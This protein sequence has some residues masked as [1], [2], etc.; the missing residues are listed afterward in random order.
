MVTLYEKYIYL[1]FVNW[2]D[3]FMIMKIN[4]TENQ[5]DTLPLDDINSTNSFVAMFTS[6]V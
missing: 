2:Y 5:W 6:T 4:Y 3:N 1:I